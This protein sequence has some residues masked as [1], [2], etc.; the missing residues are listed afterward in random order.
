ME[1]AHQLFWRRPRTGGTV[2]WLQTNWLNQV[3][4]KQMNHHWQQHLDGVTICNCLIMIWVTCPLRPAHHW[5]TIWDLVV[6]KGGLATKLYSGQCIQDIQT[7]TSGPIR[8]NY[9]QRPATEIWGPPC[10]AAKRRQEGD[11]GE[12]GRNRQYSL[13]DEK[14]WP[15]TRGHGICVL[16]HL[17]IV[18]IFPTLAHAYMYLQSQDGPTCRSRCVYSIWC[19]LC[20]YGSFSLF[21]WNANPQG[22]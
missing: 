3:W 12:K 14:S 19:R 6:G 10:E 8:L 11:A 17:W 1:H 18:K 2:S 5:R 22:H 7:K 9:V 21:L 13:L 16:H 4:S 15:P 20:V